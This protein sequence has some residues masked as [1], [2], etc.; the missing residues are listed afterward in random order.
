MLADR[1]RHLDAELDEGF[2]EQGVDARDAAA[3]ARAGVG[4][5]L[6]F[7]DGGGS[8]AH[9]LAE[10][11]GRDAV[12]RAQLGGVGQAALL[13]RSD[14]G[15]QHVG[16]E[17]VGERGEA[18]G[19]GAEDLVA[20][21]V[22]DECAAEQGAGL[23][24]EG[25][26]TEDLVEGVVVDDLVDALALG[27]RR[28]EGGDV[29]AEQLELRRRVAALV[30]AVA[31]GEAVGQGSRHLV[32]RGHE[33]VDRAA[34]QGDLADRPHVGGGGG[35]GVVDGDAASL[36]YLES[37]RAGELVAGT[38]AGGEHD[39]VG[40][41]LTPVGKLQGPHLAGVVGEE[42]FRRHPAVEIDAEGVDPATEHRAAA[43]AELGRHRIRRH[44]DHMGLEP[45][46]PQC[47]GRLEAEEPAADHQAGRA[48]LGCGTDV[49]EIVEGAVDEA[50]LAVVAGDRGDE[51]VGAGGED[52]VV[53]RQ[54]RAVVER[55]PVALDVE[56]GDLAAE[57]IVDPRVAAVLRRDQ[58]EVV[59][60]AA[61]EPAGEG[62]PVV[63]VA[64]LLAD[65]RHIDGGLG[66]GGEQPFDEPLSDHPVADHEHMSSFHS[67][68]QA[69]G[70]FGAVAR[71]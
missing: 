4:A 20:G 52:D 34:M 30:D 45:E 42:L 61:L 7:A 67:P 35:E 48:T 23:D 71:P 51:G 21:D 60:G 26:A 22:A 65:D 55:G 9:G 19:D 32:A 36:A 17:V 3:A 49:G 14:R 70:G 59:L 66:V 40:R 46:G 69:D 27:G 43:L 38:H 64:G 6:E 68:S 5:G 57:A 56:L 11:A 47:V 12:A 16:R 24:V 53:P 31:A 15:R 33:A 13:G 18:L 50:P 28:P 10:V 58:A 54:H 2:V 63:R 37:A 62:H 44:L 39:H 41:Q 1:V 25:E 29:D 8:V